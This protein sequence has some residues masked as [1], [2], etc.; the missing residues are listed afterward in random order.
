MID[1]GNLRDSAFL[2]RGLD[3]YVRISDWKIA[4]Q[5]TALR[6]PD[7]CPQIVARSAHRLNA[8]ATRTEH[9]R[10]NHKKHRQHKFPHKKNLLE[11][12]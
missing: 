3:A 4:E 8:G 12:N 9:N 6:L 1:G 2:R 11:Y 7:L 10:Y 5:E